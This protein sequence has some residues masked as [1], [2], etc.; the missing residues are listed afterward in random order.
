MMQR[1]DPLPGI[2]G[3]LDTMGSCG[4]IGEDGMRPMMC[5]DSAGE[6]LPGQT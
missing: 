2:G 1:M 4:Q 6:K 3:S 5:L